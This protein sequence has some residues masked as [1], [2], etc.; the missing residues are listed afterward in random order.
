MSGV[1]I[2][3][4]KQVLRTVWVQSKGSPCLRIEDS[5]GGEELA[6]EPSG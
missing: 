3:R 2:I 1:S 4:E 5:L 6:R